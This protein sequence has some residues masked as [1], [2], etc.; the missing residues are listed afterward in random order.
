MASY[1]RRNLSYTHHRD[2]DRF[3]SNW[4]KINFLFFGV[5]MDERVFVIAQDGR[6]DH[7]A[8]AVAAIGFETMKAS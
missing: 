7:A 4:L 2:L 5:F 6:K 3:I 8:L 1:T